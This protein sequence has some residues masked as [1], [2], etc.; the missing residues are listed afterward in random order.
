MLIVLIIQQIVLINDSLSI[1]ENNDKYYQVLKL[2]F[3][4]LK[5]GS[6]FLRHI[7]LP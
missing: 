2:D 1:N 7:T 3:N 6:Y 4:Y 5:L